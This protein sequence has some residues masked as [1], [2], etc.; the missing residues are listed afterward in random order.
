MIC[1]CRRCVLLRCV[2]WRA[3]RVGYWFDH[4]VTPQGTIDWG[5]WETSCPFDFP[6]GFSDYGIAQAGVCENTRGLGVGMGAVSLRPHSL[7]GAEL[8]F[9]H[10]ARPLDHAVCMCERV[11]ACEAVWEGSATAW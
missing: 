10:Q 6:D 3:D 7:W 5:T 2:A 4:F 11:C 1:R 8:V 9:V